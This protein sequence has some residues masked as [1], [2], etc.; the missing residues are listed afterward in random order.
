MSGWKRWGTPRHDPAA[1]GFGIAFIA[2]GA[3]G[4]L[5]SAGVAIDADMLSQLALILLGTAGLASLVVSGR[6]RR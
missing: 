4:L 2:L 5:R 1:L 3:L 6:R